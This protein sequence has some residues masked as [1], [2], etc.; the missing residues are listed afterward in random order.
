MW[1]EDA[2][3]LGGSTTLGN[4]EQIVQFSANGVKFGDEAVSYY[5]VPQRTIWDRYASM[6]EF[7]Q[8]EKL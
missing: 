3:E 6:F 1:L 8:V 7:Y 4:G 5:R 2:I